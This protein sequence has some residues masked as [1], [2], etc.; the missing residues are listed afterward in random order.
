MTTRR[1]NQWL[2]VIIGLH[3][4]LGLLYDRATP[5]LEAS[6]EG[7]HYGVVH[8][9]ALGNGLPVQDPLHPD[10]RWMQEGSQPPLYYVLAARLTS[11]ID[12]SDSDD[13]IVRNPFARAGFPHTT[14]NVNLY[15]H[16]L[17]PA[18][19][20]GTML[21]IRLARWFSLALSGFT[22]YLTARLA[23]RL[24]P[25]NEPTAI[26]AAALV[27]FNPM[28]LFIN[29][30]INN[31]NLLMLLS[32]ATLLATLHFMQPEIR[33]Y[34]AR[35]IGLGLLLGLAALT[36]VSGLVL[37]PIAA[38]GVAWGAWKGR[39]ARRFVISGLLIS[40]AA[41]GVSGWWF[42]RN[43]HLYGE[44][45]GLNTMVAIA[46][47][48]EPAITILR[49]I[50]DEF[51]GFWLSFW[52]VFG[53][54]NILPAAWVF[55]FFNVLVIGSLAGS[56]WL[57]LS[58]KRWTSRFPELL[59]CGLFI[60]LTLI[61]VTRWT[62]QTYAS[63]G[64]LMFGA[65]APLSI[66]LAVGLLA[67]RRPRHRE[68]IALALSGALTL[69]ALLMPL[70][71]IAPRYAPPPIIAES[72]LP[73]NLH[74]V[75]ATVSGDFELIG[76]TFDEVASVPTEAQRVTLYWR[77]LAP[78]SRDYVLALYSFVRDE[79]ELDKIDTWPGRGLAP[80]SQWVAGQIL[81]DT[82]H[83]PIAGHAPVPSL[84]YLRLGVWE[85]RSTNTA[86]LVISPDL[87][88]DTLVLTVGRVTPVE[89][90]TFAPAIVSANTL[91]E[92]ITLLGLDVED[93]GAITLYWQADRRI[94]KDYMVF[95]HVV[96][97]NGKMATQADGRPVDGHWPTFAWV[98]GQAFADTYVIDA[99]DKIES[100]TYTLLV[101]L[102]DRDD[103]NSRL[104]AYQPDGTRWPHDAIRI[105]GIMLK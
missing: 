85:G 36:K 95:L 32:T 84:L 68:T 78:M 29:A 83:L 76:Y 73:A 11:W 104:P 4:A 54:F 51:Q 7:W 13:V 77:A 37:W 53:G 14:H 69:V 75:H 31:D 5:I 9:L 59:L 35:A 8:W 82:Y 42:W 50:Q 49:L 23:R 74:P 66:A 16:P 1:S 102:Y 39:D 44:P 3:L 24:F 90:P 45:L 87:T 21:A 92:S 98:S 100:G 28:A 62:L 71:Y 61:G 72:E 80:T 12:V 93:A 15:R 47:P 27:A 22:I 67:A 65:I 41:L 18:P 63:Q 2:A 43:Y 17:E 25:Q 88:Q 64:R 26:L 40:A 6:D 96:D 52:G 20:T 56:A 99:S 33:H 58:R 79:F 30:S 48:R 103:P 105:D 57:V 89:S 81:A 94:P 70:L 38:I 86:P 91:G 10:E 97:Q 19:L 60:T 34:P 101:G 55:L 46:G